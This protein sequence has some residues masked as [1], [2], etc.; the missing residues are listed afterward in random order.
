[1]ATINGS[2]GNQYIDAK[3]DWSYT[4]DKATKKS[5]VTA[6]LKYKR[7]NTEYTTSGTGTFSI[8]INGTKKSETKYLKITESDW[9]T[10][11]QATVE[12]SHGSNGAAKTITISAT[13]SIPDT[14]LTST[15]VSGTVTL[16]YMATASTITG[17]AC[18]TKYFTGKFTFAYTVIDTSAYNKCN[19]AY[20]LAN[21]GYLN[22]K[23]IVLGW[24]KEGR[25]ASSVTLSEDEL[26][27]I[28]NQ[29]PVS[30]T[31]TLRFTLL[32]YS[33]SGYT[34]QVGEAAYKQIQLN[35]PNDTMTQPTATMTLKPVNALDSPFDALYIKGKTKVDV[36]FTNGTGKFGA[37]IKSYNMRV[38]QQGKYFAAPHISEYLTTSGTVDVYG[39]VTDSRDF[40]REYHK[41]INVIEYSSPRILPPSGE[42]HIICGRC[43]ESGNLSDSGT[44]LKIR[45]K[46]S[47]SKVVASGEQKNFCSIRYRY[48]ADG[49]SYT[50]WTTILAKD[51][52][53]D[54]VTTGALLEGKLLQTS[55]YVVQV[56][57]IDDLGESDYTTISIPTDKIYMHRA[58][59][60]RSLGIGQYV[61]EENTVVIADDIT[62]KF[63]GKV[64][65][66]GETWV[67]LDLSA[68]VAVSVP[69]KNFGRYGGTGCYYRVCAGEKH[70]YVAFN[71]AFQYSGDPIQVNEAPIPSEYCPERN[72]YAICATG[73]RAVARI[74]VNKAGNILVDWIQVLSTA[75]V[76]TSSQVDWID[77]YIDYWT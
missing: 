35:I 45:A 13:G 3:I 72:V 71:C 61:E 8:T 27:T 5:T 16:P 20:E 62:A 69:E 68:N 22:I 56:G 14:S 67:N 46:R 49:G 43:D 58:G 47:Y 73:G 76:T 44:Y 52:S 29:L 25:Y 50:D 30:G 57:V 77:G 17:L 70:V 32:T 64:D 31:G 23:S 26:L 9:V 21:G 4:Q 24:Q 51:A 11:V 59:S 37:S 74:L 53:S 48:K 40:T 65:F 63:K 42:S 18:S 6:A 19:I 7:N 54:E 2:T 10:A 1:M 34:S 39:Y 75:D 66:A 15:S 38:L 12:V 55:A 33:N 28:Y 60:L 41:Q 36:D